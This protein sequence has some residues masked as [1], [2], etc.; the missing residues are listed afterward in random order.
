MP[1]TKKGGFADAEDESDAKTFS[2]PGSEECPVKTIKN[3]LSH[4]N[5]PSDAFFQRPREGAKFN[6]AVEKP[7][8]VLQCATHVNYTRQYNETDDQAREREN[9]FCR[10]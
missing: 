6:P 2:V 9:N 4:L 5:P 8:N 1:A 7:Y 10:K 3:Y